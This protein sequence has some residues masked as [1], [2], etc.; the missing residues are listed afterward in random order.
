MWNVNWNYCI[1]WNVNWNYCTVN[2]NYSANSHTT[3]KLNIIFWRCK[4]KLEK[5]SDEGG[6]GPGAVMSLSISHALMWK[7]I[8]T[9][10]F[11]C[12]YFFQK[13]EKVNRRRPPLNQRTNGKVLYNVAPFSGPQM[14]SNRDK[15]VFF[16]NICEQKIN[17]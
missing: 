7:W 5:R 15:N 1:N 9:N 3:C 17:Q 2:W 6:C 12:K 13:V 8:K 4:L 16:Q 14:R 10:Y 11:E